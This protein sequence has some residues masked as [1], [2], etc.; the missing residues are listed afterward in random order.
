MMAVIPILIF[1][2]L[3]IV[4][5][6]V[7]VDS[8]FGLVGKIVSQLGALGV[9]AWYCWYVTVRAIPDMQKRLDTILEAER[10]HDEVR[11]DKLTDAIAVF[12][13]AYN[14]HNREATQERQAIRDDISG[15]LLAKEHDKPKE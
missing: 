2:G 9:L 6:Q 14:L 4:A 5:Q 13:Q 8:T 12:M 10:A 7:P 11:S 3:F 15:Y 1:S